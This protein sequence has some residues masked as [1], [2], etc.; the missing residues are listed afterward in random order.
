MPNVG[1]KMGTQDALNKLTTVEEGIFY[2]T[3]DTNRLYIG[4]SGNKI[5]PVNEGVQTVAAVANLPTSESEGR[6]TGAFY[7]ATLE[8]IL[9]VW[10]GQSWVQINNIITNTI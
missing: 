8:N 1:F 4:K 3:S 6:I 2:L 9:C 5:A 7:Y 10:N